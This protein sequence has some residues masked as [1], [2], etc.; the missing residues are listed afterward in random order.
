[1]YTVHLHLEVRIY[2]HYGYDSASK[3]RIYMFCVHDNAPEKR[4]YPFFV[5]EYPLLAIDCTYRCRIILQ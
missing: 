1:M 2:A 4:I 5:N 3:E